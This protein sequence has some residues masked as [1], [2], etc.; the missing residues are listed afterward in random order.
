MR[1]VALQISQLIRSELE[2]KLRRSGKVKAL[3]AEK[4][5]IIINIKET[6]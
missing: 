4:I 1:H 3:K 5:H 6:C 2:I